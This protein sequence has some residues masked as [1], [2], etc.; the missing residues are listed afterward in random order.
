MTTGDLGWSIKIWNN[1]NWSR[2][3]VANA[4]EDRQTSV[5]ICSNVL[6]RQFHS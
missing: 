3:V 6:F 4:K 5:E 1:A 2:D